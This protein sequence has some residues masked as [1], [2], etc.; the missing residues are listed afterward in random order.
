[1]TDKTV[2][3]SAEDMGDSVEMTISWRRGDDEP[4]ISTSRIDKA[5][6]AL[7]APGRLFAFFAIE[8]VACTPLMKEEWNGRYG[9]AK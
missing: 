1:M 5:I 2:E 6:L 8:V 7:V 4:V 9:D 3:I